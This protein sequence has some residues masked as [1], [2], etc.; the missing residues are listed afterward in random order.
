MRRQTELCWFFVIAVMTGPAWLTRMSVQADGF[1]QTSLQGRVL[2]SRGA[3]VVGAIVSAQH[4]QSGSVHTAVSE[5]DGRYELT[6]LP[7]GDYSVNAQSTGFR[8]SQ[9]ILI[10][11]AVGPPVLHDFYLE[12][13][14][15]IE[16]I[17]VSAGQD[18]VAG[19]TID[20]SEIEDTPLN[21]RNPLDLVYLSSQAQ[22]PPLETLDLGD[23]ATRDDVVNTPR[24]AGLFALNGGRANSNNVTIDGLD[25]NDD[26]LARERTRPSLEAIEEVRIITNR[27][28]AEYGRAGGAQINFRTR[29]GS[30]KVHGAA[31]F[32]FQDESLNANSFFRNARR[33]GRLPFQRR[34]IGGR[35]SGPLKRNRLFFFGSYERQD[36]PD[37]DSIVA[38]LPVN[39]Q[40]N[41]RYPLEQ[42]PTGRP[43]TRDGVQVGL[44]E[45]DVQASGQRSTVLARFDIRLSPHHQF[46]IR[47]DRTWSDRL[48]SREQGATLRS[49]LLSH[50]RNSSAY[51]FQHYWKF[52]G[53]ALN[54]LRFQYATLV[55]QYVQTDT[56][57]GV[58]VGTS[59]G[60]DFGTF[61]EFAS[62]FRAGAG[63]FPETLTERRFQLADTLAW[64]R[65]AHQFKF[66][67]EALY[68][69]SAITPGHL[70]GGFYNFPS[71]GEFAQGQPSRFRQRIGDARQIVSNTIL[72]AF[73]QDEWRW[74]PNLTISYGLRYDLE[75]LLSDDNTNFSPRL[76][77]AWAPF[78]KGDT[79]IRGGAGIFYNRVL[80]R[81]FEEYAVNS[82]LYEIDLGDA[83][84]ATGPIDALRRI[85]G[86]PNIFPND[87]RHPLVEGLI[88]PILNTRQLSDDLR[89]PRSVQFSLSIEHELSREFSLNLHYAY[90][91]SLRL[92]REQNINAPVPPAG[93]W[94]EFLLNPPV[95]APGV[96]VL[97]DGR[98]AF[99][100]RARQITNVNLGF[101][102]FDLS[103]QRFRDQGR[104]ATGIRTFGLNA[105]P[106]SS[107]TTNP[108]F[109]AQNAV[110]W[111]RPNPELGEIGRL[112]SDGRSLYH[113]VTI[114]LSKRFDRGMWLAGSYTWSK[115]IDDVVLNTHSPMDEFN[116]RLERALGT[117]D[118]RHRV[119]LR[120]RYTLPGI[121]AGLE[122]SPLITLMS[123]RPFNITTNG[124]DRNLTDTFTDRPHY[125]G[126][127][128]IRYI[129]PGDTAASE[130][131]TALFRLATIGSNGTLGRN[132][133]R[134]P[135]NAWFNLR[136][137]RKIQINE[138]FRL[139]PWV[140]IYNVLN[141]ANFLMNGF[142]GPL[143][144]RN[145]LSV[146][147]QPRAARKPRNI[148][149]GIRLEF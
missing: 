50:R 82:R 53:N 19:M 66:G 12:P 134:G 143:D 51:A 67:A 35:L 137:S 46:Y 62:G 72:G 117:T 48:R 115:L 56:R 65:G 44:Y 135:A 30:N 136:V 116:L 18:T 32:G 84:G 41:P 13:A 91:R 2:D 17:D 27:F 145:D 95:G 63:G 28:A 88:R 129:R 5:Q 26:R 31:F 1:L 23:P 110:R 144:T 25:N 14:P 147:L 79:V 6:G 76:A 57:P 98:T 105:L 130:A 99:D 119:V 133:G 16:Q 68:L 89:L 77:F 97:P 33:Q 64:P 126:T 49:A 22:A 40:L 3:A 71:F 59:R 141:K 7:P 113:G 121:L 60:L 128:P 103:D 58:I 9:S 90:N 123:G 142:Y 104:G 112:V 87:P 39:P 118:A 78:A 29:A 43:F 120:G 93:G 96:V 125:L 146:F 80:L 101:V 8:P 149:V 55:P 140:D 131:A 148:D 132:A 102:R 83:P 81:S 85:G 124:Q 109:A 108:I 11:L 74:R 42:I 47:T 24:D 4:Q 61:G 54:H 45:E 138:R 10:T 70:F 73:A 107:A 37:T 122:L 36:E 94:V 139:R 111:R 38:L 127:E 21:G 100:N 52:S 20:S 34:E 75:T 92:W 106:S 15:I 69:R 86:F 114:S